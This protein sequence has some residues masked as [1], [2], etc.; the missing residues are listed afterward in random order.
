MPVQEEGKQRLGRFFFFCQ[1]CK[2]VKAEMSVALNQFLQHFRICPSA[3]VEYCLLGQRPQ[4]G[5]L[6]EGKQT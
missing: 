4:L 6:K 3:L 2:W 5:D 1:T